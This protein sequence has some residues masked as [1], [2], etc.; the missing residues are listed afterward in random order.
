MGQGS[1]LMADSLVVLDGSTF[2][3]SAPSGDVDGA[4]A[5]GFFHADVR[6]LSTWR[7]LLE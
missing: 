2:F 7:L 4:E 5:E 1:V 6:H 3:V